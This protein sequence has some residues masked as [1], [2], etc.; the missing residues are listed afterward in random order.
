MSRIPKASVRSRSPGR[1]RGRTGAHHCGSQ[2]PH[3]FPVGRLVV[4]HPRQPRTPGRGTSSSLAATSR[5]PRAIASRG[6]RGGDRG[7]RRFYG[8]LGRG[9][10]G[11]ADRVMAVAGES[12]GKECRQ[13]RKEENHATGWNQPQPGNGVTVILRYSE[14]SPVLWANAGGDPS[15]LRMTGF[16]A[17]C[18]FRLAWGCRA[19]QAAPT[20]GVSPPRV[21]RLTFAAPATCADRRGGS[22]GC[23]T[24]RRPR[25]RPEENLPHSQ[26][27]PKVREPA[28]DNPEHTTLT[29]SIR[30]RCR[31]VLGPATRPRRH[32]PARR[33]NRPASLAG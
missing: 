17:H 8:G 16:A 19:R 15:K 3:L 27:T 10:R 25:A 5:S 24:G 13:Q 9:R 4:P 30:S 29:R 2:A 23:Q 1:G 22:V 26:Q 32:R 11:A 31:V 20:R 21:I 12:A 33:R 6:R 14:G 18:D 7:R 28:A